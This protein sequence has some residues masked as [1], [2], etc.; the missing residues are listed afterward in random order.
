MLLELTKNS[1]T[2]N[3]TNRINKFEPYYQHKKQRNKEHA[4]IQKNI[5]ALMEINKRRIIV[6]SAPSWAMWVTL[7]FQ[8]LWAM[9]QPFISSYSQ[10]YSCCISDR[11]VSQFA[12]YLWSSMSNHNIHFK[13]CF[14]ICTFEN[15]WCIACFFMFYWELNNTENNVWLFF[16]NTDVHM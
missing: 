3:Y 4:K 1:W 12:D 5:T 13:C 10:L 7:P 16:F 2:R 9:L 6:T 14:P 11:V 15:S 8:F